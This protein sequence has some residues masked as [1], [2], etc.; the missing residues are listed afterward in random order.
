MPPAGPNFLLGR[1]LCAT[2]PTNTSKDH[3][4]TQSNKSQ[5]FPMGKNKKHETNMLVKLLGLKVEG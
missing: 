1:G 5:Q 3:L 4:Q 2:E